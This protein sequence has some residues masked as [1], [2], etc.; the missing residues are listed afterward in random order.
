M[1]LSS[2]E[3]QDK[4][5]YRDIKVHLIFTYLI[6]RLANSPAKPAN[7]AVK[8]THRA[9]TICLYHNFDII[10][11]LGCRGDFYCNYYVLRFLFTF[12]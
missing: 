9:E 12:F 8:L 10:M 11:I 6:T 4:F 2:V 7:L 3:L 5:P 1:I